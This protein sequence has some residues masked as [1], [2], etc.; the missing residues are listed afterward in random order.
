MRWK[1]SAAMPDWFPP[2]LTATLIIAFL[3]LA[4]LEQRRR[5]R[6]REWGYRLRQELR[7]WDGRLPDELG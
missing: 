2:L 5:A 3:N 6:R 1:N 4:L 7:D